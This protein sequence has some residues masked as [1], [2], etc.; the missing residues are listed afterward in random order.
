MP[1]C[2]KSEQQIPDE[3]FTLLPILKDFLHRREGDIS[4]GQQQQLSIARAL[5]MK[6]E[7][8]LLDEPTERI[9]PKIIQQIGK[10]I[11]YLKGK[12]TWPSCWW[13]SIS[14]LPTG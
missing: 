4:G 8:L 14:N 11:G 5:I 12:A 2:P 13:S 9:Q 3:I 1:S 7:V 6:P 10:V